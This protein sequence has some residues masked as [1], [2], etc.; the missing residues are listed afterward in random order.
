M[1]ITSRS[2]KQLQP[3]DRVTM[4][5]ML[6]GKSG[7][8][9]MARALGRSP[10]TISREIK[11]NAGVKGYASAS[12]H[13]RCRVRRQ[14]ARPAL[15]LDVEGFSVRCCARDAAVALVTRPSCADTSQSKMNVLTDFLRNICDNGRLILQLLPSNA[16]RVLRHQLSLSPVPPDPESGG[17]R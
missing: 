13:V 5:S 3:E 9:E 17:Q 11:R 7:V 8:R 14:K 12:A 15:K 4:A 10:S 6:Q 16:Y 2:Y 1:E